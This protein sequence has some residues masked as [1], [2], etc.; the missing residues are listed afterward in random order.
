MAFMAFIL[1]KAYFTESS[2]VQWGS[3]IRPGFWMVQKRLGYQ[4][5]GFR[6]AS[7]IR[8]HN[9]LKSGQMAPFCQKLF[10]IRT[11]MSGFWMVRTIAIAMAKAWTFENRTIKNPTSKKEVRIS[12]DWISD[13]HW[14]KSSLDEALKV[15]TY[16]VCRFLCSIFISF[17]KN[18][19]RNHSQRLGHLNNELSLSTLKI[20]MDRPI[21]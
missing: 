6:M 9:H 2:C 3:K 4:W 16:Q 10:Q 15:F 20:K 14:I 17:C 11:K 5:S 18:F 12:D 1:P 19:L 7:E 8:K 21:K 13:P